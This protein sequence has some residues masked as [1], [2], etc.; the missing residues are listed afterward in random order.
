MNLLNLALV[1]GL[2]MNPTLNNAETICN[3][4]SDYDATING[5]QDQRYYEANPIAREVFDLV[6]N[7]KRELE[8]IGGL[9]LISLSSLS[10]LP[11]PYNIII[12]YIFKTGH[13]WGGWTWRN[14]GYLKIPLRL[15]ILYKEW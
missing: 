15:T 1:I 11:E 5:I 7:D 2:L 3:F 8:I 9:Y 14:T 12:D 10:L 13:F 6:D 4:Y